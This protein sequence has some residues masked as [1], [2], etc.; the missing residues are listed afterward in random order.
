[1]RSASSFC[2]HYYRMNPE[3]EQ[4]RRGQWEYACKGCSELK[5]LQ[6]GT[7][8]TSS[9]E[10]TVRI[11]TNSSSATS[12]S[13]DVRIDS[14]SWYSSALT[15][16]FLNVLRPARILPPIQVEYLRSGGA[17]I[18]I[19]V[20]LNASFFTS[21]NSLSPNPS[22]DE[23]SQCKDQ[24]GEIETKRTLD[25]SPSS[26]QHDVAEET[27]SQVQIGTV[28]GVHDDLMHTCV[29]EPNE[30]G[31]KQQFWCSVSFGSELRTGGCQYS[32]EG[33]EKET[34]ADDVA[35]W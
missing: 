3:D 1:M 25:E 32:L 29:L 23:T 17:E 2:C 27:L 26:T 19:F 20:S 28:D 33:S 18:L 6:N 15:H 10:N 12:L 21:C 9:L 5:L 34:H 35:V 8:S 30:F 31:S 7:G 16:I 4:S 11:Y 13:V 22:I 14:P 24:V